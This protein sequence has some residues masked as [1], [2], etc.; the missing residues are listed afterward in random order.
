MTTGHCLCRAISFAYEGERAGRSIATA[1]AAGGHF[2]PDDD[3]DHRTARR[4][5]LYPRRAEL[6]ASS[7]G[8]RRGF[9]AKCG[10][11]LTYENERR[12]DEVDL[13]AGALDDPNQARPTATS[14]PKSSSLG[15][16]PPTSCRATPRRAATGRRC[17]TGRAHE[18]RA[19]RARHRHELRHWRRGRSA[20][21]RE[22]L[23]RHGGCAARGAYRWQLSPRDGRPGGCGR[24]GANRRARARRAAGRSELGADRAGERRRR[25]TCGRVQNLKA[26]ELA[27][28]LALNVTMPLWLIG[29]AAR[30]KPAK[31]QLRVVN[32]VGAA[33]G[34][35]GPRRVL[36]EQSCVAHGGHGGGGRTR[37]RYG[38][39][40]L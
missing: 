10:S 25:C 2:E 31:A 7:L 36:R 34:G 15:S 4:V 6:L 1:R 37:R 19:I 22:G 24:G 8:V 28:A 27:A 29:L 30:L 21:R 14:S 3:V 11:P 23:A 13:L 32:I 16:R 26:A 39:L 17:A 9:C 5:P 35:T 38:D 12:P 18:R 40:Q 20:A 33:Q